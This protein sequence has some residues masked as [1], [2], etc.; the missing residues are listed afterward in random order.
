MCGNETRLM[1]EKICSACDEIERIMGRPADLDLSI[2]DL[3]CMETHRFFMYLSASDG[4]IVQSESDYMNELFE[5]RMTPK[6]YDILVNDTNT[7][8][9]HFEEELPY[10]FKILAMFEEKNDDRLNCIKEKYPNIVD[11]AFDFYR[12]AGIEFISC[13]RDVDIKEI[14]DLGLTLAKKKYRLK[15][16]AKKNANEG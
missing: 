3:F 14:E 10:S 1:L 8:S 15:L 12:E 7:Y 2:R 4:E 13:D 9:S 5:A 11:T 6:E 16:F